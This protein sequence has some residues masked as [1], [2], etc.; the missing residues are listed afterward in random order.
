MPAYNAARTIARGVESVRQQSFRDWSLHV[1]DDGSVDET[2]TVALAAA[3]GDARVQVERFGQ[4]RGAAAAMN[5]AWRASDSPF[6]AILDSD[7][8][9]MPARLEWQM[10]ALTSTANVHVLGGAAHFVDSNGRFMRTVSLP[11]TH[12]DLARRRWYA[13]PFVH[14]SV[15]MRRDFLETMGG[16]AEDLRLGEDYDLW[17]RGFAAGGFRYANLVSPVVIYRARPV[18]RWAMIRASAAV[19]QRAGRREGRRWRG[20]F[21]A[22]RI[23]AEGALEQTGYF[24]WRDRRRPRPMPADLTAARG[25]H[26]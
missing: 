21:A 16:Y 11:R 18:Q 6:I 25:G 14:P 5:H 24:D 26:R 22:W 12:D 10:A 19:R 20:R 17:M 23:L 13:C 15:T 9:A 8:V 3:A 1:V 2:F 4:N 7:D